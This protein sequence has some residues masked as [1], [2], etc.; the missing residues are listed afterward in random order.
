MKIKL[1]EFNSVISSILSI[2]STFDGKTKPIKDWMIEHNKYINKNQKILELTPE[3]NTI[4]VLNIMLNDLLMR[5]MLGERS[6]LLKK[7]LETTIKTKQDLNE[8]NYEKVLTNS[9]YRWKKPGIHVIKK[10]VHYFEDELEWNWKAY[11]SAAEL[12]YSNNFKNDKLLEIKNI[13]F[14]VR[15]LAL[16]NFNKHYAAFDRHITRV[17]T[18][19]GL[20]NYGF[21]LLVNNNFE[22]GNNPAN[23]RNYSF[24]HKLFLKLSRLTNDKYLPVDIDRIFW[25]FGRTICKSKPKC[26]ICPIRNECLTGIERIKHVPLKTNA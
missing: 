24:F 10:V 14:K 22:M 16:S 1:P 8:N 6:I 13:K 17:S 20:L 7:N 19:I 9:K 5:S 15:D 18:R 11:F 4:V 21:D 2:K 25:H 26:E 3:H 23:E 12:N